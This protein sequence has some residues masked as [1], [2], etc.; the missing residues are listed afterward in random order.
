M[1]LIFCPDCHDILA[2]RK[3]ARECECGASF[4]QY[5]DSINARIGGKAIPI[6]FANRSFIEALTHRPSNGMGAT[7]TAFVI[8]ERVESIQDE[9]TGVSETRAILRRHNE[10]VIQ[11]FLD[12]SEKQLA[13]SKE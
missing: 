10:T 4:G 1:K 12:V 11:F 13:G 8:P 5:L 2:L 7:F 6:G 9:G 3:E